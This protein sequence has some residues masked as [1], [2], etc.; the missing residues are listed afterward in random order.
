[1]GNFTA[2]MKS[3]KDHNAKD[4]TDIQSSQQNSTFPP[5]TS[6][7]IKKGIDETVLKECL[8]RKDSFDLTPN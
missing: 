8:T 6:P 1:M 3:L 4:N 2:I 5:T 7:V